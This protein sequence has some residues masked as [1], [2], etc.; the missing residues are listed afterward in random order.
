[1][2]YAAVFTGSRVMKN[3]T[4]LSM[5][6]FSN[7]TGIIL[8]VLLMV[9]YSLFSSTKIRAEEKPKHHTENGFRNYPIIPDFGPVGTAF[10]FR[11]V[12][13]SFLL[14]DV[15]DEHYLSEK[16]AINQFQQLNGKNS[17]T[18]LGHATFL[19]RING[20]TILTDPF[21]TE[22][23]SPFWIFGSRRF[24]QPGI[25]LENLPAID[26]VVVSHNHLDHLDEETIESL[27]GKHTIHVF[28]PL[29]LKQFFRDR[30]YTHINE[31]DWNMSYTYGGIEFTHCRQFIIL[32][33]V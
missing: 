6:R 3:F 12:L 27:Q 31:L 7:K 2:A 29:G 30:G 33:E 8:I 13:D 28:V 1:M 17:I 9:G 21:L 4:S 14:P 32:E 11:R 24:V 26:I 22:Y 16:D 18:W 23:A 10:Y 5:P 25:S 15:P 19:I 20:M